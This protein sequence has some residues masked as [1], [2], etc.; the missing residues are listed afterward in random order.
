MSY[1]RL[2][3]FLFASALAGGIV[4]GC[5]TTIVQVAGDSGVTITHRDASAIV[6]EDG[7]SD[8]SAITYDMTSGKKC[9]TNADCVS[10]TGPGLNQCSNANMYKVT[11]VEVQLWPTPICIVPPA[12]GGNCDPAPQATDPTGQNIHYCD[13]PDVSTSPGI[14]LPLSFPPTPGQ[15]ACL[16]ACSFALDG[17]APTGCPGKDTCN[18]Y[19]LNLDMNG[20]PI[21]GFGFCQG[22]CQVD[23]DCSDLGTGYVC[24]TD[25]GECTKT[26]VKRT[27][28][29]GQACT[30]D[31]TN[32][33]AT[34]NAVCNCLA[35]PN[36]ADPTMAP[37]YCTS[38]CIV[39]GDPCPNGW[40]CDNLF[41]L[42][43]ETFS[44][45]NVQ[46]AGQ[47]LAPCPGG[48]GGD[49]GGAADSGAS[50]AAPAVDAGA[51][52]ACPGTST[53]Q[54]NTPVGPNCVP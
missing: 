7:G 11:G 36:A 29:I 40:I 10:P 4:Q 32:P 35:Q 17:T 53:C 5:T 28:A 50:D 22:T 9:T 21:N 27:K 6:G 31:T 20:N 24:Q 37:G 12:A 43:G 18:P 48:A 13:G 47:C 34:G 39:G 30:A 15:G 38:S 54:D 16:P 52:T 49:A 1:K 23:A 51:V 33:T 19:G 14:C 45:E 8:A 44:S 26:L 41:Q 42:P 2:L 25:I 3:A 46:T